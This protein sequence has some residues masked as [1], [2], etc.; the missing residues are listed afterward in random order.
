MTVFFFIF[1]CSDVLKVTDSGLESKSLFGTLELGFQMD[2]DYMALMEEPAQGSF[3]GAFWY[4]DEVSSI[5]PED[6]AISLGSILVESVVLPEDGSAT[7]PLFVQTD[8]PAEEVVVL[9]FLDSDGN[10]DSINPSAFKQG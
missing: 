10:A 3:Y 1:G 2:T 9:G 5:G 7:I 6:G 4:G 8:L